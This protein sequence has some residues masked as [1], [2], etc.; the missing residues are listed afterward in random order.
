MTI[1]S[2]RFHA[3]SGRILLA[4]VLALA[5]LGAEAFTFTTI[6][7]PSAT[8]TQVFGIDD[9][10]E[11]V[12]H[13]T[14]AGGATHGFVRSVGG[15][16][17]TIDVPGAMSTHPLDITGTARSIGP[18]IVGFYMDQDGHAH[19]FLRVTSAFMPI[20]VPGATDT[21]AEGINAMGEIVGVYW[22]EPSGPPHGFLRSPNG[23]FVT[24][25]PEGSVD[26]QAEDLNR[27]GQMVGFYDTGDGVRR[28]FLRSAG[29]FSPI[30]APNADD[31]IPSGINDALQIVGF[32]EDAAGGH[33]FHLAG[34]SFMPI[35]VPGAE[36]TDA[37]RINIRGEVVGSY[38]DFSGSWHGFLATP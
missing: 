26:T 6:D 14:D 23:F 15:G 25:D 28:G 20:D 29:V 37:N 7:V 12:G 38:R 22:S 21:T 4:G 16:F 34:T 2:R 31:T 10:G 32:F 3:T 17:T 9:A 1:L 19:G 11:M 33:G 36:L 24:I 27:W 35:D 18:S 13:Y 8:F 5:P 30:D